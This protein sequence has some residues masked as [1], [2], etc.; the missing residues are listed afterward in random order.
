MTLALSI[1]GWSVFG[2]T[3]LIALALNVV[4]LFGNWLILIALGGAWMAYGFEP[5]GW[6]GITAFVAFAVIGE[7]LETAFAG[8][9]ARKFGGSKG[10]MVAALVGCIL[11]A[12]AGTPL[13]PILGTLLG[14]CVGAFV[15][16]AIYEYLKHD[17]GVEKSLWVGTGAAL[18]K[19]GGM[20]AKFTC[21]LLM[22]V[23]AWVTW[24]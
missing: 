14:A 7:V 3:V 20:V 4:G 9:G 8:Y 1:M 23:T 15:G 12:V 22:L 19:V 5:F 13:F 24:S 16:A 6:M 11:G 17:A 21:G 18:G 10:A 2:V